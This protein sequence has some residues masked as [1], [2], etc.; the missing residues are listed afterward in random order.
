MRNGR[1][2]IRVLRTEEEWFGLTYPEDL[3]RARMMIERLIDRGVYPSPLF[4]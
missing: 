2:R 4:G 1:L 3:P